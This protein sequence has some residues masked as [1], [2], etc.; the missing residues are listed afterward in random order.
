MKGGLLMARVRSFTSERMLEIEN[1]TVVSGEING[2]G[3][4]I[5][6]RRDGF[7]IDAGEVS[8]PKGDPG[9]GV[10]DVDI[11]YQASISGTVEPTGQWTTNIPI[12]PDGQYLWVKTVT[13]YADPYDP[14]DTFQT[15]TF[16][17]TKNALPGE[18]GRGIESA[19]I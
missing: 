9:S 14:N 13:T 8:G 15:T 2:A 12:V 19:S 4:L 6:Y 1:T 3:N 18:D 7:S 17:V 16:T 5:L 10:V 11:Y